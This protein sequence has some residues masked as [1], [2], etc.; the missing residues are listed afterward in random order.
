MLSIE[1][2]YARAP[3]AVEDGRCALRWA[4]RHA[5]EFNIDPNRII[6]AGESTGGHLA[7]MTG[8]LPPNSDLDSLCRGSEPLRMAAIINWFGI[9][10]IE[11]SAKRAD[12]ATRSWIGNG[13]ARDALVKAVS[14]VR[15]CDRGGPPVLTIHADHDPVVPHAQSERLHKAPT[16]SV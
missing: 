2:A 5:K 15:M 3:G 7:L 9:S 4:V 13:P 16:P 10:D 1:V 11:D 8:M 12:G 6:T 14:P